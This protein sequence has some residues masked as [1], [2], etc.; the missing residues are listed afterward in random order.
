[1]PAMKI[2]ATDMLTFPHKL[3]DPFNSLPYNQSIKSIRTI[4]FNLKTRP[5]KKSLKPHKFDIIVNDF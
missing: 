3:N 4:L 5:H 1:M 2:K